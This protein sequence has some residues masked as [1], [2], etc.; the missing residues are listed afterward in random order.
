MLHVAS[1][2]TEVRPETSARPSLWSRLCKRLQRQMHQGQPAALDVLRSRELRPTLQDS[3]ARYF[4]VS[5][6]SKIPQIR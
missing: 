1:A 3:F 2:L 6:S 4:K 5:P